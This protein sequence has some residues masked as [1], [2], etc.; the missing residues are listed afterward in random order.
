MGDWMEM[1]RLALSVVGLL[2]G[3]GAWFFALHER[4]KRASRTETDAIHRRVDDVSRRL[5][6][7]QRA[8][9]VLEGVVNALPE[10]REFHRLS[11]TVAETRGDVRTV[12]A[13]VSGIEKMLSGMAAQLGTLNKHL[14]NRGQ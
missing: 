3:G 13:S 7:E 12:A 11:N 4:K 5:D 6:D 10:A 9:T 1:A 8:R 2:A 14:L